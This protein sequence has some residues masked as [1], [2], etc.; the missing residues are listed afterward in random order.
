M[1]ATYTNQNC[2]NIKN[3]YRFKFDP[4]IMNQ[5]SDFAKI[6]QFDER[7]TFKDEWKRWVDNNNDIIVSEKERLK[8]IGYEGDVEDKMFKSVRYYFRNKSTQKNDPK[9]RRKYTSLDKDVLEAM[10]EH[11]DDNVDD[12]DYTPSSGYS[13]FCVNNV[14]IIKSEIG[15]LKGMNELTTD[16]IVLKFKKTYKN[17][18]FQY[19]NK[20]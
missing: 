3:T 13:D 1:T 2:D 5:L 12:E 7:H 20:H 4:E 18:Y 10:D 6:H 17:R 15:R 14:D 11:I 9:K 16:E 19:T 8:G